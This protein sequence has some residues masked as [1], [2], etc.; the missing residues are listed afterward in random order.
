MDKFVTLIRDGKFDQAANELKNFENQ[1]GRNAEYHYRRGLLLEGQGQ[2]DDAIDAF[3]AA[4]TAD[5]NHVNA[6][7]RLAFDLDLRGEDERAL[8]LYE[9]L[10][11][12][13]P[14][15]VNALMNLAILYEDRG[16]NEKA[17]ACVERVLS[18]YPNHTRAR[19][20]LKDMQSSLSMFY[21]ESQERTRQKRD[22]VMDTPV[23]DFELSVRSRN[24]LKK[25]NINTLGDL[26]RISEA[27]LLAYKNFG[28]T[29]LNE[30]KIMLKQKG[31]RLGQLKEETTRT[32][33]PTLRRSSPEGSPEILS[34]FLSEIEFSSRSRKCLQRLGL[35]TMGDLASK[36]EIELLTAKN[37]GQTSLNEIKQKLAEFGM[38]LR[39]SE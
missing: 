17:S 11:D 32:A 7:F 21:D 26:L 8:A 22:A 14:T 15:P 33:R 23:S 13:T 24:C 34:K 19:L 35:V 5:K 20:Y 25:M 10:A 39:K 31:L 38:G 3:D 27:E 4:V 6:A 28:E 12:R 36:T 37:F 9:K 1:G 18:E 29:S 16:R 2:M 30:I